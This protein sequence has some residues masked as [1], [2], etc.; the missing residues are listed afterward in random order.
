M[1]QESPGQ[2]PKKDPREFLSEYLGYLLEGRD[3][4]DFAR[5]AN[6]AVGQTISPDN[7]DYYG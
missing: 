6:G 5:R 2:Q 7:K 4:N 1:N 3:P